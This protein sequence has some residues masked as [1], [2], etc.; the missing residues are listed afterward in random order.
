[1][2]RPCSTIENFTGLALKLYNHALINPT[3][4]GKAATEK[5]LKHKP[6][7]IESKQFAV[8]LID[9]L[10]SAGGDFAQ[11]AN[12]IEKI[13]DPQLRQLL[14]GMYA[15][16]GGEDRESSRGSGRLVR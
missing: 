9:V 13:E 2:S 14:Q 10:Q 12:D 6:S 16:A 7:Y 11:L 3:D 4:A 5:D 8:A 15:R 1:M